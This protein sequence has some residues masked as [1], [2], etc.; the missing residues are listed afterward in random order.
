MPLPTSNPGALITAVGGIHACRIALYANSIAG[1]C[2]Y[3]PQHGKVSSCG[4]PARK[5]VHEQWVQRPRMDV[6]WL[7]PAKVAT[8]QFREFSTT[9]ARFLAAISPQTQIKPTQAAPGPTPPP[10]GTRQ[11]SEVDRRRPEATGGDRRR[12]EAI[13]GDRRRPEATGGEARGGKK[14]VFIQ[15]KK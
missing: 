3:V 13:G 14:R 4:K 5:K 7:A 9:H 8:T 10:S 11:A 6:W 12:P 2:R 1:P 15:E